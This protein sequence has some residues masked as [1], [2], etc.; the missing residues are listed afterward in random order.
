MAQAKPFAPPLDKSS[1]TFPKLGNILAVIAWCRE[2]EQER[3]GEVGEA[4]RQLIGNAASNLS[5]STVATAF[6]L[7]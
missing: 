7:F 6:N 3:R 4:E 5:Y 1:G 2:G